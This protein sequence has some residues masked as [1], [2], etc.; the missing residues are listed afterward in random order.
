VDWQEDAEMEQSE[1]LAAAR[2]AGSQ[3]VHALEVALKEATAKLKAARKALKEAKAA[4]KAAKKVRKQTRHALKFAKQELDAVVAEAGKAA[5][6]LGEKVVGAKAKP[7]I[8]DSPEKKLKLRRKK[9]SKEASAE[10]GPT[11]SVSQGS[12]HD[13]VQPAVPPPSATR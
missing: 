5:H 7:R 12:A 4:A 1:M 8:A 13:Q 3:A 6:V 2:E 10:A 9:A 11:S